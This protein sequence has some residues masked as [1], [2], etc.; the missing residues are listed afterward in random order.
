[1]PIMVATQLSDE[2][3]AGFYAALLLVGF[4]WIIPNHLGIAMFALDSASGEHFAAGLSTAIR[5]SAIVSL[6][7]AVVTPFVA[8]PMLAIFGPLYEDARHCLIIL[9]AC[10]FASATKSIYIAVRRAEGALGTAAYAA[11]AGGILE[12]G[13]VEVGVGL[14]SV[15]GV[16]I[17]LGT[18]MVVE[19]AFLAPAI[20]RAKR[21]CRAGPRTEK[22]ALDSESH[23]DADHRARGRM[24]TGE[25]R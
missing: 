25:T 17:A 7:A 3:N 4:I 22:S 6:L 5:L 1:M 10:T 2:A 14:G 11:A 9:A 16:G 20:L 23:L 8:Y 21:R 18:A 19:A 24:L 13:A 15:T 12:L